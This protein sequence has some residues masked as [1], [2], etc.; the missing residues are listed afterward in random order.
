MAFQPPPALAELQS[1]SQQLQVNGFCI[2]SSVIPR[3]ECER[4]LAESVTPAMEKH[5]GYCA[6]T[7][8]EDAGVP[9]DMV[10]EM[11]GNL[12]SATVPD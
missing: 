5:S 2:M 12:V 1:L 3:A 11:P 9:G 8:E 4:F 10:R 7:T 6:A